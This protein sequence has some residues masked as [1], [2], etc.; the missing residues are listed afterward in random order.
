M[1]YNGVERRKEAQRD[2][3]EMPAPKDGEQSQN[4]KVQA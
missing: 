1:P 3:E 2:G 4:R